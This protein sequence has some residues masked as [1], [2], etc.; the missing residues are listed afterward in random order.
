MLKSKLR[1]LYQ[2]DEDPLAEEGLQTITDLGFGRISHKL[3]D[4]S[5]LEKEQLTK[6]VFKSCIP[7]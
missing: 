1:R 5:F 3:E 2:R 6:L 7:I 4:E